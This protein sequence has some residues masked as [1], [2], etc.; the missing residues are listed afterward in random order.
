MNTIL[1]VRDARIYYA[2]KGTEVKAVDGV[3]FEV[4][5]GE[6]LGIVGESGS[7]KSTL[8]NSLVNVRPPMKYIGGDALFDGKNLYRM[9]KEEKKSVLGTR[10]TIIPQYALDALPPVFRIK[11]YLADFAKTHGLSESEIIKLA[12][13]RLKEVSLSE[14]VLDMYPIELS[15]GMRQRVAIVIASLTSPRLLLG[16]EI[17][18][19]LDVVTQKGIMLNIRRF[20]DEGLIGSA[21]L[22]T[23]DISLIYQVADTIMVMYAG[24][25]AEIAPAEEIAKKPLHPYTNMLISSLT[26]LGVK[27]SQQRLSGIKGLP[28]SLANPPPG[29]RFAPRCPYAVGRCKSEEP[30]A[31]NVDGHLVACWLR[32]WD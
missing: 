28:P 1:Q 17:T 18:S 23:H 20:V 25:V 26:K 27:A 16:D 3:S 31:K 21:V 10:L 15:G 32:G 30:P 8:L 2:V 9:S 13:E 12:R 5:E 11:Q 19:A 22:V 29:C 4:H 24:K 6:I 14:K 7:G